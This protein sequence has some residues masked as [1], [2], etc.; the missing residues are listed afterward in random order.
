MAITVITVY[1]C[2][3]RVSMFHFYLCLK[4][5]FYFSSLSFPVDQIHT[6]NYINNNNN[7]NN[8]NNNNNNINNSMTYGIRR[9]N[10]AF[11]RAL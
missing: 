6:V 10:S 8:N 5:L 11:T 3:W 7:R 9:F 4:F 2:M 1:L